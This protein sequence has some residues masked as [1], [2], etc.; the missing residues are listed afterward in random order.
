MMWLFA[1]DSRRYHSQQLRK[2]ST[3]EVPLEK[4]VLYQH[5][6]TTSFMTVRPSI[7]DPLHESPPALTFFRR[8]GLLAV[9]H[10][11]VIA[12]TDFSQSISAF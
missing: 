7:F 3:S 9:P 4:D 2:T 10:G 1:L 11:L 8:D 6:L 5:P 12:Y